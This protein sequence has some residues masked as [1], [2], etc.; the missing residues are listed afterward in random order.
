MTLFTFHKFDPSQAWGQ[1]EIEVKNEWSIPYS[2]YN[3][4]S[5]TKSSFNLNIGKDAGRYT[6]IGSNENMI[7]NT[8][9]EE[10]GGSMDENPSN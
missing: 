9:N 5:N 4:T 10:D 7:D 1:Y 2:S 8:E 3:A 6:Q